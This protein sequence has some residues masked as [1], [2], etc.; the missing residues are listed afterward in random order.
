VANLSDGENQRQKGGTR[1]GKPGRPEGDGTVREKILDAAEVKFADLGYAGATL[2]EVAVEAEVTQ[3]LI[4]Y[5]FG[6]KLGL[7]QEVFFR[8]GRKISEERMERLKALKRSGKPLEVRAIILA[9]LTPTLLVR[10]TPG[11]RAF[12]R[13]QARV[14]TEPPEISYKVRNRAYDSSTKAYVKALKEALPHL[15]E[16]DIYWR[17]TL[18]VGAYMY[19]FSDTHRLEELAKGVCNPDDPNE[20]LEQIT[21]FVVAG[22]SADPASASSKT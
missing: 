10:Q 12:I 2:R 16:K 4:T 15:S 19:A 9:L 7:F 6:S 20:V 22:L 3:G 8:R 21:T 13:L 17:I 5:Y 1:S 14:H 18:V 11:G